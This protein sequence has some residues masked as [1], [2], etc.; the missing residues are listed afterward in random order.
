MAPP[1]NESGDTHRFKLLQDNMCPLGIIGG[2]REKKT[3]ATLQERLE[4]DYV[5]QTIHAGP[6]GKHQGSQQNRVSR[7]IRPPLR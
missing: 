4:G 3:G 7:Q 1:Q 5:T 2:V 6:S